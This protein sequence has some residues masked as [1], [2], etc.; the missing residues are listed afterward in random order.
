MPDGDSV[1]TRFARYQANV[2]WNMITGQLVGKQHFRLILPKTSW[3]N[4]RYWKGLKKNLKNICPKVVF[5]YTSCHQQNA[6]PND[7]MMKA[8]CKSQKQHTIDDVVSFLEKKDLCVF[9]VV[10][11]LEE[12]YDGRVEDKDEYLSQVGYLSADKSGRINVVVTGEAIVERMRQEPLLLN[13][14]T[15]FDT[16]E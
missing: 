14:F 9:L 10:D 5:V 3:S 1:A 2:V 6:K 7:V 15:V 4:V 8:L 16:T 13:K 12:V 11:G